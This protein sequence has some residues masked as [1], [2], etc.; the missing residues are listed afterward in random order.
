MRRKN[1]FFEKN[2]WIRNVICIV[3]TCMLFGS[4]LAPLTVYADTEEEG[5]VIRIGYIEYEGFISQ[6]EDGEYQGYGVDY[7]NKIAEY[8]GWK[9]EYVYDTWENQFKHL[10]DG[11]IDFVCHAQKT[12][13]REEN[14]LFSKYSDGSEACVL[15]VKKEDDRYYYN[16]YEH[17]NGMKIAVLKDSYQNQEVKDYAAKKGFSFEETEYDTPQECFEALDRGEMDGVAMGSL[18]LKT[19]YKIVCKFGSDP[20]YFITGKQNQSLMD[21][22]DDA[23]G[24][25][26]ATDASFGSNL[27]DKY[28]GAQNNELN[29][30]FTREETEF[31]QSADAIKMGLISNRT[32]FS[33]VGKNGE[34]EGI[35]VDLMKLIEERSGLKFDYEVMQKGQRTVD[36]LEQNPDAFVTGIMRENPQFHTGDYVISDVMYSDDV[37]LVCRKGFSYQLD[38]PDA[39]YKLAIPVSYAALEEYILDNYPQFE[40]V[41]GTTSADCMKMVLDGK[42]DFMAQNVNVITPLMQNP[43]YEGLTLLPTFFMDE[44]MGIVGNNTEQNKMIMNIINKCIASVSDKEKSQITINHTITNGYK[45]SA[46]DMVYK[47]RYPI[48]VI[49]LLMI[50]LVGVMFF[51]QSSKRKSYALLEKKNE[52]LRD[53]VVQ[54]DHANQA[55]SQFLA[56]MSHEIRTPMNAI[57]G[58]TAIAKHHDKEPEKIDEYLTKIDASSQVLLN[59][60]N[61]VLDMSAIES[62]KIKIAKSS[63][64]IREILTSISTIYYT[65]C[66]Q[67]GIHFEMDTAEISDEQLIGDGL[68]LNQ[69][70]LNLVSNAYKFT[71]SG[72]AIRIVAKEVSVQGETAYFNF[73]VA[74]T[75]EGMTEEM[76]KRIFK[77]FEQESAGT[78]QKHGGSGLGLSIAKNLVEMM[79]GSISFVSEKDVG[80]TFTVSMPFQIDFKAAKNHSDSCKKIRALIVD[81]ETETGEYTALVLDRIGVDYEVAKDAYEALERLNKAKNDA[82]DF[83]ICFVDWKMQEKTGS[84]IIRQIRE[85]FHKDMLIIIVSAYDTSEIKDEA[86]AAGADMFLTKPIFQSTV[87]NL[88]MKLFDGKCVKR[89]AQKDSYDF[90]GKRVLLAEDTDFNA[91]IAIELLDMVNMKVDHAENGEKA[92]EMFEQA[93]EGTYAAVLMDVQMPVMD[94]YEATRKIRASNHPQAKSIPIFAMTANAFTE[95]VSAA[96]N[97]GMNGHIAKPIDTRVLYSSLDEAINKKED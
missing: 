55:K 57:V 31:I 91:E 21:E 9:Y 27:F 4:F 92:V 63:F 38:A 93:K 56:R 88:L 46:S 66:R 6:D 94:G 22:M 84:E 12:P 86:I 82:K 67:K 23:L 96:L 74:D 43:H 95:D 40:I 2:K 13:D 24:D 28:Y 54:A 35:V 42:A 29:L 83:Q 26:A 25:I 34:P 1:G 79:E 60:I 97:A 32:P 65:Q 41:Q 19:E 70:F 59:I 72:G 45:P 11:S 68:R 51:W 58:L 10:Q 8:T 15:Y 53:A 50:A 39:T 71:P 7:L 17:F 90:E 47:F 78:A 36:Y 37:S 64:N 16:D 61:D 62:D 87:F 14:Y 89:T 48:S 75:G 69:I 52:Q 76:Q 73:S 33:N 77:P 44:E 20:F 85:T 30:V 5:R 81:N 3:L 49:V 80:T 18:A